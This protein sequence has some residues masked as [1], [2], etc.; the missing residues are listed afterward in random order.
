MK[1]VNSFR[2]AVVS[3]LE[4][5]YAG[6]LNNREILLFPG[7]AGN[8]GKYREIPGNTGKYREIPGNTGKYR[9]IPGIAGN[10]W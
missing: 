4:H 9:E 10:Y 5:R 7:T 2:A 3:W 8:T 6:L 1:K